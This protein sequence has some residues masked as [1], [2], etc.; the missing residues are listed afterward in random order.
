MNKEKLYETFY[1]EKEQRLS[2]A[3]LIDYLNYSYDGLLLSDTDGRIFY[4]NEAVERISGVKNQEM[5]GLTPEEM[6]ERGFI[7]SQSKKVLKKN[8]LTIVQ[9]LKTGKEI[10]TTSRPIKDEKGETVCYI[11][12]FRDI[13][14]LNELHQEHTFQRDIDYQELQELRSRFLMM[15]DIVS[16]SAQMRTIIEKS[17]KVAQS[18]ATVLIH[19][20]S[21]VGKE[22]IAKTIHNSSSRSKKPYIQI[23]CGA[24]PESLIEAELFGYE[25]GA[26]TG[27]DRPKAG[28]LEAG[29]E[30]TVLLDEIGDLPLN[31]Q[32]KLLRVI[33]T[34][35]FYR[36][37]STTPRQLKV[38]FVA[39]THR[40]LKE[41]VRQ[42][43]FREDLFYRLNVVPIEIPPLRERKEEIVPLAFHFLKKNNEK[44]QTNKK[45]DEA[46]CRLLEHYSWPG[47]IRQLENM[48]ERMVIM[49]DEDTIKPC[50]IPDEVLEHR[51]N[52]GDL[53]E[54][55]I[56]MNE[57][58]IIPLAELRERTEKKM[59]ARALERYGS[60][61]QAAKHL[62]VNHSTIVRKMQ[63][64]GIESKSTSEHGV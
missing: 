55:S 8:P 62:G 14:E 24:I 35:D 4:V 54:P 17:I 46:T 30:G 12:T 63:K 61:R 22:L 18:D 40:D 64:Y 37:G 56:L 2:F 1:D 23:N 53:P 42:G 33:Q 31:V 7:V 29:N 9:K 11:A 50:V 51:K 15:D 59:I 34:G 38:R 45:L 39:A 10:F 43:T 41:M 48:I 28:L 27:A 20:E 60:I 49:S 57:T 21:G 58:E 32:V 19:G 44:Y 36:V 5:L 16:T 3:K 26:F 6:Q 13:S 47:N 25:K 52:E